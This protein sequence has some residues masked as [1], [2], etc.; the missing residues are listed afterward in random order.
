[1]H[2]KHKISINYKYDVSLSDEE[3]I[4]FIRKVLSEIAENTLQ[5]TLEENNKMQNYHHTIRL[6]SF[7]GDSFS[8]VLKKNNK[9]IA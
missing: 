8:N 1:M 7:L 9:K 5:E 3:R 6:R 4:K 2:K